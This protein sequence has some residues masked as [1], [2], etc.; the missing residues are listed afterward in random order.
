MPIEIG[1]LAY[2]EAQLAAVLGLTDIFRVANQISAEQG[3]TPLCEIRVSHWELQNNRVKRAFASQRSTGGKISALIIPPSFA[4]LSTVRTSKTVSRWI[5]ARRSDGTVLCSVCAGAF[6][7][8]D[9]GLLAGRTITTHWQHA[10]KFLGRF[11]TTM[12]DTDRIL[13][14]DGDVISAGGGMAW[15]DLG[16]HLIGKMLSPTVMLATARFFLVDPAGRQQSFYADFSP[17]LQHGDP[18]VLKLQHWLHERYS[19]N[20]TIR[21]MAE[22]SNLGERT[23]LRRFHKATGWNPSEYLQ[24]WRIN[25]AKEYLEFSTRNVEEIGLAVGYQDM[26]AF[27]NVFKKIVGLAPGE[28][29]NRFGL[30]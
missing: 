4:E 19:S 2:P 18:Q 30:V 29:R 9:T 12:L 1:I 11:P 5:K 25:K 22:L 21:A 16:L 7:L 13:I 28:Y 3:A 8:A 10:A 20:I 26:S 17:S 6:L 15:I 14:D 27:R 23:L 24:L